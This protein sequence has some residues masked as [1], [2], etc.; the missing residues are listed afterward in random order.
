MAPAV[1]RSLHQVSVESRALG[2]KET[3][4]TQ[5]HPLEVPLGPADALHSPPPVAL[6]ASEPTDSIAE[7][8]LGRA[9]SPASSPR[10]MISSI[11]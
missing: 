1:R 2:R 10:E 11:V 5:T 4:T 6:P 3:G 9:A 7:R 8:I